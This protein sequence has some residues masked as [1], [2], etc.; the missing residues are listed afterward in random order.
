MESVVLDF[1]SAYAKRGGK[2]MGFSFVGEE[3]LEAIEMR[4][5]EVPEFG[6]GESRGNIQR[7][8]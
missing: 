7:V 8:C 5:I 3:E 2:Q 6:V 4:M 1:E